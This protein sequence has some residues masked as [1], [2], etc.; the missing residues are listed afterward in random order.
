MSVYI[1]IYIH[2]FLSYVKIFFFFLVSDKMTSKI[3]NSLLENPE[4]NDDIDHNTGNDQK[5]ANSCTAW[6]FEDRL[7]FDSSLV[8]FS[9]IV[10][11]NINLLAT[12]YDSH[13]SISGEASPKVICDIGCG[14]GEVM[15]Y[16]IQRI[17]SDLPNELFFHGLDHSQS[18]I[19]IAKKQYSQES[20]RHNKTLFLS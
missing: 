16:L 1:Y 6:S 15:E 18:I 5:S 20:P 10:I 8:P 13:S 11:D 2:F 7:V 9:K 19:N 12:S 3:K 4:K 14:S 17:K